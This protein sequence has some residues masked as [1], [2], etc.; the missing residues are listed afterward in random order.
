[1]T[2]RHVFN[3]R[4]ADP[5]KPLPVKLLLVQAE[6]ETYTHILL[7]I[8]SFLMFHRERLQVE[9]RLDDEYLPFR[10]D[11]VQ[12]DYE[13]RI[14]LWIECGEC[15]VE[16]LDRLAVK[17]PY[18]EIWAVRKSP[19]DAVDLL[20]RMAREGL[21]KNR[22]GVVG[23]DPAMLAELT[24]LAGPRNDLTWHRCRFEDNTGGMQFEFNGLW[25]ESEFT[26][27]RH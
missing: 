6:T 27:H 7:K 22:Y 26:V 16:K 4:S 3:L 23:L 9:P 20:R 19:E 1:M 5:R 17:A 8:L 2:A 15:G 24:E 10:P 14:T 21:R 25:F 18:G 11:V 13:G 12:L